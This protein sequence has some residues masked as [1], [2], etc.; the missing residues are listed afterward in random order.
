[1]N[2]SPIQL[3]QS[4]VIPA[5]QRTQLAT[6]SHIYGDAQP[7]PDELGG[8]F[9]FANW[10]GKSISNAHFIGR[11]TF[12][13]FG[14]SRCHGSCLAVAPRI[15]RAA[16][17]LRVRGFAA[18]AAF[19]DIESPAV[20]AVN[21]IIANNAEDGENHPHRNNWD[22]RIAMARL[23]L[24]HGNDLDVLTGSRFQL[25]QATAA[26][27]VLREHVPPRPGEG[28]LSINHSSRIY[29]VGPDTLIAG[30]GYHDMS[31]AQMISLVEQLGG[32]KRSKIDLAAIRKRYIR[33]AGG[34]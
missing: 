27:H 22:K 15:A 7:S 6:A 19:V 21:P 11:W 14:Y 26:F 31:E 13:Y 16:E 20:G 8:F 2:I 1:M 25:A 23:A 17:M 30:Y 12:L 9:D 5:T 32:A 10:R 28:N 4:Y 18:K 3:S 24:S 29:L 33:G 34:G